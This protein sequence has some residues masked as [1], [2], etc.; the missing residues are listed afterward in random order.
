[1]PLPFRPKEA[2]EVLFDRQLGISKGCRSHLDEAAIG[3]ETDT[4]T[5]G[6]LKGCRSQGR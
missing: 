5:L 2:I 1:V 6:I 4:M 3:D